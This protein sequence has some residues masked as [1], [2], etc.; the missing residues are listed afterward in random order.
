MGAQQQDSWWMGTQSSDGLLQDL[1]SVPM[2]QFLKILLPLTVVVALAFFLEYRAEV[3]AER[4]RLLAHETSVIQEGVRRVERGLEI[5]T[6]DLY[7]IV[8]LVAEV[9]EDEAPD[10]FAAL[11]RSALAFVRRR[12]G[13]FQIR[14]IGTTGQEI[15]RVENTPNGPRIT[16]ESELQDE[17]GRSYFTDTMRLEPGEVFVSPAELNVERGVLEERI[18]AGGPSGDADR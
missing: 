8:D 11:E 10:R 7:F 14:F 18:Q 15:L 17:S 16:P 5:A 6:G 12:P 1:A 13:Y 3:G 4:A 9:V 2:P